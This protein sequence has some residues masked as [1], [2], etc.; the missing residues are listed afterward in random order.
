MSIDQGVGPVSADGSKK[1]S[2]TETKTYT[3]TAKNGEKQTQCP[4]TVTVEKEVKV[5]KCEINANPTV[6]KKGQSSTLTWTSSQVFAATIDKGVGAVNPNGSTVVSP[7][8]TTTYTFTGKFGGEDYITCPVTIKVEE[9]IAPTCEIHANPTTI[10]KGQSATL[11]WSSSRVVSASIDQGIG[12]V[13]T[14]GS[15][16]VSPVATTIYT[17][18]GQVEGKDPIHCPVTVTVSEDPQPEAPTCDSFTATPNSF[19]NGVGGGVTL[20]W[21]TTNADTVTIDH[22]VGAVAVDGSTGTSVTDD[23]TFTLTAVKGEK[24]VSCPVTVTVTEPTA[25][26]LS[27]DSFTASPA[28]LPVGGGDTVLTW[29]TTDATDVSINNG[30]GTVSVDGS[31]TINVTANTTFTLTLRDDK[32]NTKTCDASVSVTTSSGGGGG[33][34]APSCKLT[35]SDDKIKSGQEV[36]LSWKNTRTNDMILEDNRGN[37]LVDTSKTKNYDE[38]EDSIKVKPTRDTEYTMTVSRGSRDRVCRVQ[39]EME[40]DVTVIST[41]TQT[42]QV[43][44]IS[45]TQV[46]YTGFEA[47][48]FLTLL[49]YSLL[50]VWAAFI[51]YMI[52][53]KEQTVAGVS[54]NGNKALAGATHDAW[55]D[56][57]DQMHENLEQD[58]DTGVVATTA[59]APY[60]S[61]VKNTDGTPANLPTGEAPIMGYKS[62]VENIA[63]V[64]E[65]VVDEM[66]DLENAAH[67]KQALLSSDAINYFMDN[68]SDEGARFEALT[69]TIEKAKGEFPSEGGWMVLNLERVQELNKVDATAEAIRFV[70]ETRVGVSSLAE[71]IVSGNVAAAYEMI[72]GRPMFALA[73]AAADLDAVYRAR[74]GMNAEVSSLLAT[75]TAKLSDSQIESIIKALTSALDGAYSE[76]AAAVK[77][78]IMK[79]VKI[80]G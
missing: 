49:F 71:A 80:A 31:K 34:S 72:D 59:T 68:Y 38:D 73:D 1:V 55:E 33:S 54:L 64:A 74:K 63:P 12:V 69:N 19:N 61:P 2:T 14:S 66:T 25:P 42:P 60:I 13:N 8:E 62:L 76:E 57:V 48:P 20:T 43:A 3:L 51:A 17:F 70:P 32:G 56:I 47:G 39:V 21:A 22:G 15:K 79:A 6:I 75:S 58:I 18:T 28:T 45:L 65:E 16:I 77:M 44:G 40:D 52:V 41:R 30:V 7:L 24:S 29:A 26:T 11:T 67:L 36:T 46:P 37:I 78:A 53:I 9:V 27:C 5:P 4:V 35:I 50:A 23:T 10:K